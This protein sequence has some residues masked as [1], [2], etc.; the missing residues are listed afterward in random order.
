MNSFQDKSNLFRIH[1]CV[2][3]STFIKNLFYGYV[4][5]FCWPNF[6]YV[7][8]L[9]ILLDEY[10]YNVPVCNERYQLNEM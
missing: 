5:I 3:L 9:F 10:E 7:Q 4:G 2:L 6:A 8:K 1:A